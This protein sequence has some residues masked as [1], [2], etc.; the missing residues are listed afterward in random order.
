M[1]LGSVLYGFSNGFGLVLRWGCKA[2]FCRF[3]IYFLEFGPIEN[4]FFRAR[5]QEFGLM[6]NSVFRIRPRSIFSFWSSAPLRT[7][8]LEFGPIENSFF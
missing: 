7:Q 6:E 3:R 2:V 1:G 5:P 8:F 4:C